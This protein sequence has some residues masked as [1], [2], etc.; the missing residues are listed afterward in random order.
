MRVR[1]KI[2]NSIFDKGELNTFSKDIFHIIYHKG[3]KNKLKNLNTGEVLIRLYTD[4]E[5]DQPFTEPPKQQIIKKSIEARS[6]ETK[7][8]PEET[9]ARTKPKRIVKRPVKLDL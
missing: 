5:I 9:I 4:E 2:K 7:L 1:I 8:K 6:G 3:Q